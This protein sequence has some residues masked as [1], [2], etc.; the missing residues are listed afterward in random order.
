MTDFVVR[1]ASGPQPRYAGDGEW[2]ATCDE[3]G[4]GEWRMG[5]S[6]N[7]CR[8]LIDAHLAAAHDRGT[9]SV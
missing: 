2:F 7:E 3:P 9:R 4:C 5:F 1:T 6:D 8:R